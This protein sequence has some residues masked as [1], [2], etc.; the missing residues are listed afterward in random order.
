[1]PAA[2]AYPWYSAACHGTR[3][4]RS[5]PARRIAYERDDPIARAIAERLVAIDGTVSAAPLDA[6][7]LA[8]ALAAGSDAVYIVRLPITADAANPCAPLPPLPSAAMIVPLVETRA[9][10]LVRAGTPALVI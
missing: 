7:T 8:A 9:H 6:D 10:A 4:P 3:A 1:R 2:P 5:R